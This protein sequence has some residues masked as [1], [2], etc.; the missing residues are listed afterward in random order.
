MDQG[1]C[2]NT[3]HRFGSNPNEVNHIVYCH[4]IDGGEHRGN[5][6]RDIIQGCA[7]RGHGRKGLLDTVVPSRCMCLS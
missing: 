1:L 4:H 6:E 3:V 5:S 2:V 7:D